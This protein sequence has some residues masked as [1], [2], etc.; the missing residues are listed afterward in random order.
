MARLFAFEPD[1]R[2]TENLRRHLGKTGQVIPYAVAD[3]ATH[4]FHSCH[5]LSG[6][7]SLLEPDPSAL[8]FFNQFPVFGAVESTS[9]MDTRRLDDIG[10]VPQ[11]DFLKMDIQGAELM[12]LKNGRKKLSDCVVIQTE[13]SFIALYKSQPSFGDID[14]ELRSQNLI[15]HCLTAIKRWPITPAIRDNDPRKPFNQLLE[16]DIV[17]IRDIIHPD[18]MSDLQIRKLAT[19]A[20]V[21]YDSPDLVIRCLAELQNRKACDQQAVDQYM[22]TREL[23]A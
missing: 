2:E 13:I 23:P 19:I 5:K 14:L 9:P 16:A 4:I 15:P 18:T 12:V 10:E 3:G 7:S 17:Y 11:I 20:H 21:V 8:G 6:M 1:P 22:Q